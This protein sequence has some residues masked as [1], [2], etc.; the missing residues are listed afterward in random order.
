MRKTPHVWRVC[1]NFL[2]YY[3]RFYRAGTNSRVM[4]GDLGEVV[5]YKMPDAVMRM[6]RRASI[7]AACTDGCAPAE[8][9]R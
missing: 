3:G 1:W 6:R 8:K 9:F 2:P 7:R 4:R 5:I